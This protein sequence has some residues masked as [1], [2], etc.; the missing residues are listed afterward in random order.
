MLYEELEDSKGVIRIRK[1]KDRQH[2]GQTKKD[3]RT[4][5]DLHSNTHKTKDRVT[6]TPLTTGGDRMCSGR[7]NS[8]CSTSGTRRVNLLTNPVINE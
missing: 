4:N 1:S 5:N 7:V 8:S 2:N 3:K 6:R